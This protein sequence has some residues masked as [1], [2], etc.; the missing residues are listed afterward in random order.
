MAGLDV[1]FVFGMLALFSQTNCKTSRRICGTPRSD[2]SPV[3][4]PYFYADGDQCVE[5]LAGY[6]TNK[7]KNCTEPC[8]FPSY[9]THCQSTCNCSQED[10]H[11]VNGC[12]VLGTTASLVTTLETTLFS[13]VGTISGTTVSLVTATNTPLCSKYSMYVL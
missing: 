11:H 2:R 4:C 8:D 9:G 6:K 1:K 5:C 13:V 3:C 10:C 7:G 12:P